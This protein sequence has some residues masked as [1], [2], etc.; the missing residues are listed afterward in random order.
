MLDTQQFSNCL[1]EATLNAIAK[2]GV[3]ASGAF[4]H[5]KTLAEQDRMFNDQA[6]TFVNLIT[7]NISIK[8]PIHEIGDG[9]GL[10][11]LAL[12]AQGYDCVNICSNGQRANL[13]ETLGKAVKTGVEGVAPRYRILHDKFPSALTN[14]L[15]QNEPQAVF[16]SFDSVNEQF[17]NNEGAVIQR[18]SNYENVII[19]LS[20]FT[21]P[22]NDAQEQ[23]ELL[24]TFKRREHICKYI[25]D[26]GSS[27][28]LAW[29][30]K[31]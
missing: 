8:H 20:R 5:Y 18:A 17:S 21:R 11:S 13:S 3:D 16:I 10:M 22:R 23:N 30:Q 4:N 27:T 29:L 28:R 12:F 31:E 6:S 1:R 24:N 15:L 19:N 2:K 9:A 25:E 7:D 26:P 14:L